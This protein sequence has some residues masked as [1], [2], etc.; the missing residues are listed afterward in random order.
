MTRNI[1]NHCPWL[2]IYNKIIQKRGIRL[3]PTITSQRPF[4][5]QHFP[6]FN[7]NSTW[8]TIS[9]HLI[10]EERWLFVF[11]AFMVGSPCMTMYFIN[12]DISKV[13]PIRLC[14]TDVKYP[15]TKRPFSYTIYYRTWTSLLNVYISINFLYK[16]VPVSQTTSNLYSHTY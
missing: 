4:L 7:K 14:N 1:H 10:P 6:Y 12:S 13:L 8:I 15:S 3:L 16:A 11:P 9:K 5:Y 2:W